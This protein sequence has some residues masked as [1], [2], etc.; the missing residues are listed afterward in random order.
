[1]LGPPIVM[2]MVGPTWWCWILMWDLPWWWWALLWSFWVLPFWRWVLP[3]LYCILPT[4][5]CRGKKKNAVLKQWLLTFVPG[6]TDVD[7]SLYPSW[8]LQRDWLTV[9]LESYKANSGQEAVVSDAEVTQLHIQVC[10]FSLVSVGFRLPTSLK[11]WNGL[12]CRASAFCL[13]KK[14]EIKSWYVIS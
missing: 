10:K 5:P 2:I 13:K 4:G 12:L 7:Y 6:V 1:M 14:S 3:W 8:E 9:Y 11:C